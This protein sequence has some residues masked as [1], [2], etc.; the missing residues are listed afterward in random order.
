MHEA[1][2]AN[3]TVRQQLKE[4]GA[5]KATVTQLNEQIASQ[6]QQ[7]AVAAKQLK[8]NQSEVERLTLANSTLMEEIE[9]Y[10]LLLENRTLRGQFT[11]AHHASNFSLAEPSSSSG[12]FNLG[13]ELSQALSPVE[14][15]DNASVASKDEL[16]QLK[17]ENKALALYIS[18]ILG[19]IMSNPVLA[20]AI[21]HNGD[22]SA[23]RDEEE[24]APAPVKQA[25]APAPPV[26]EPKD[27]AS[28]FS[29]FPFTHIRHGW[30][31]F[32]RTYS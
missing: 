14:E 17:D 6:K 16:R 21:T 18:K 24:A 1:K 31:F 25:E 23:D 13:S 20:E 8:A 2:L 11:L 32:S 29:G 5:L 7:E 12:G 19:K 28:R 15:E 3:R 27:K 4:I 30:I 26:A 10:Q 9:S 22:S